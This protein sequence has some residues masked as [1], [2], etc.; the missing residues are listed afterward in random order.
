MEGEVKWLR[1]A[2]FEQHSS[3]RRHKGFIVDDARWF[4]LILRFASA[5]L[6]GIAVSVQASGIFDGRIPEEF[7]RRVDTDIPALIIKTTVNNWLEGPVPVPASEAWTP[8]TDT[9]T[10]SNGLNILQVNLKN[11]LVFFR[12]SH[13]SS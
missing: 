8:V 11:P 10:V 1:P 2:A 12:L 3:C 4:A 6:C 13:P 9:P 5:G 7:S